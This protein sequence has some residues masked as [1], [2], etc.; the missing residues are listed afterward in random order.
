MLRLCTEYSFAL[1]KMLTAFNNIIKYIYVIKRNFTLMFLIKQ[2][3]FCCEYRD[4]SATLVNFN[5]TLLD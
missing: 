4:I 5:F 1:E 2:E 3:I